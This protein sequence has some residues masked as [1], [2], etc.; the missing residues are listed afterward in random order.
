MFKSVHRD[1]DPVFKATIHI[2]R[3]KKEKHPQLSM[4]K[5]FIEYADEHGTDGELSFDQFCLAI[6]EKAFSTKLRII[7]T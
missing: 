5:D 2:F 7:G 6:R 1:F 3:Q 4:K